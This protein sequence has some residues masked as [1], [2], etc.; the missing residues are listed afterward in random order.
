[1][2]DVNTTSTKLL[3][4][5]G[6]EVQS[7]SWNGK[8]VEVTKNSFGGWEGT[9]VVENGQALEGGIEL[10]VLDSWKWKDS[11]PE[12]KYGYDDASL[13]LLLLYACRV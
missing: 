3:V 7:V 1:M 6:D 2:G 5:G 8:E 12:V 13:F 11:L 9:I 10:P 4:Y